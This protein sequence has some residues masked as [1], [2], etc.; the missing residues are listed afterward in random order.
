MT[1]VLLVQKWDKDNKKTIMIGDGQVTQGKSLVLK[2]TAEKVKEIYENKI[3]I[4]FAGAAADALSLFDRLE[5][6][7]KEHSGDLTRACVKLTE[8]WRTDKVL[9]HLKATLITT[10][11]DKVLLLSG[12]GDVIDPEP[13]YGED[14]KEEIGKI[15]AIGAG[16]PYAEAAA[17]ALMLNTTLSAEAI[18]TKA[19]NIASDMCIFTNNKFVMKTACKKDD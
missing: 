13:L 1:T 6:K 16:G 9:R 18:A 17:K 7:L 15:I 10:D 14:G 12:E 4:G 8:E 11:G 2:G 19:M 5:K 3:V